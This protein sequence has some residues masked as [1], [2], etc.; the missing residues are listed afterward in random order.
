MWIPEVTQYFEYLS[1]ER[2]FSPRTITSYQNDLRQFSLFTEE[3]YGEQKPNEINHLIIREWIAALHKNKI[4][5]ASINRKLSTLKSFFRFLQKNGIV[6]HNPLV[7]IVAPKTKKR[8]PVFIDESQLRDQLEATAKTEPESYKEMLEHSIFEVFYQ[9][10][11]RRSEL[12]HLKAKDVD[13]YST[14]LR[15]LGKRNKVRSIPF[16]LPLKRTLEKYLDWKKE[17]SLSG[18][19]FFCSEKGNQLSEN[20]VYTSIKKQIARISTIQK[21]SPHVLRHTFATHLLNNGADINAVKELLGHSSLAA[22]QVY[23]HNTIEK[24]KRV[25]SQAHPRA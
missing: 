5:A 23:T 17:H 16:S 4:A 9:T 3:T 24:L 18:E 2:K 7:K 6:D 11:L 21:K 10:G 25:Y 12:I 14:S 13:L 15:V 20:F 8:L 22:T 1:F 19:Y